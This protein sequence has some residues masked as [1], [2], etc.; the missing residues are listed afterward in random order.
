VAKTDPI[1]LALSGK[2]QSGKDTSAVFLS[3]R[4]YGALIFSFADPLKE[5][6]IDVLGMSR[7]QC[8]GTD[9]EKNSLTQYKWHDV[10]THPQLLDC[11]INKKM[12][13]REVMQV[14]GTDIVRRKFGNVWAKATIRK[15]KKANYQFNVIADCRFPNEIETVLDEPKGYVIRLTRDPFGGE[16]QHESE[17]V[18]DDFDWNR[19]RCFIIDNSE[20]SIDEQNIAIVELIE[21]YIFEEVVELVGYSGDR[22]F[23]VYPKHWPKHYNSN[24]PCDMVVGPCACG[25]WHSKDEDWVKSMIEEHGEPN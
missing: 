11:D 7:D 3:T 22:N 13:A 10:V 8:Y 12:T 18:L 2:K 15:I 4:I 20:M 6:C 25:A 17:T 16:D 21:K 1:I 23:I 9:D 5:F 24:E 19:E 14:F